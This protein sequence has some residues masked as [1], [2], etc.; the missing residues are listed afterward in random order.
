MSRMRYYCAG[1]FEETWNCEC[2]RV[3]PV[4]EPEELTRQ[5]ANSLGEVHLRDCK[6]VRCEAEKKSR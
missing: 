2:E 3:D 6:C 5:Q 1:C 4:P